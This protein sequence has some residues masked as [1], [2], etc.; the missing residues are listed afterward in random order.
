MLGFKF[1]FLPIVAFFVL[2]PLDIP[3]LPKGVLF[4]ELMMPLAVAN[5]NL[6]SLYD[7]KPKTVTTLVFV[8]SVAFLAIVFLAVKIVEFL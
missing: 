5:V 4:I 3:A 6:A 1:V 8:S 2:H 7:C